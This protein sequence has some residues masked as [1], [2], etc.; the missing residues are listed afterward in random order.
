MMD[1]LNFDRLQLG[2]DTT[3]TPASHEQSILKQ[4]VRRCLFPEDNNTNIT[5]HLIYT[6]SSIKDV[7][8]NICGRENKRRIKR[9]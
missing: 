7:P 2:D 5:H 9:L 6:D 8:Y 4:D 1:L 3:S